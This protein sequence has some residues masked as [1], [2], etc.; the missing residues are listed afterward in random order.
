[1]IEVECKFVSPGNGKVEAALARLGAE[2]VREGKLEDLYFAHPSRDFG[3]SDEAL[4]LRKTGEGAELTYKGARMKTESAKAREEIT[5]G[6]DNPLAAQR[7][8][9]RLGFSEL[10][11]VRKNRSSYFLDKLRV[12]V[13]NVEDLGEYVELE[14]LTEAPA[15]AAKLS[16]L[17]KA[18]LGLEKLERRTYLEMLLEKRHAGQIH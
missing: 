14:S 16:Q 1:M 9:E 5:L 4:R 13:D 3:Q 15:R 11:V 7:I 10:C 2:K 8:L 18:E 17:A 12:D 6:I